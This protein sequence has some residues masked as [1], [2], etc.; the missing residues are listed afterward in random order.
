MSK[1]FGIDC[2][3]EKQVHDTHNRRQIQK[4]ARLGAKIFVAAIATCVKLLFPTSGLCSNT[5][6]RGFE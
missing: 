6:L 2:D 4:M 1:F 5:G 3:V